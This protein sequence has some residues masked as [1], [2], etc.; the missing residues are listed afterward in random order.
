LGQNFGVGP[1][2]AQSIYV[3]INVASN[4]T[5]VATTTVTA[6]VTTPAT[7]A[8]VTPTQGNQ[9]PTVTPTNSPPGSY[10]NSL[11]LGV[12][13][14]SFNGACPHIFTFTSKIDMNSAAAIIFVLEAGS[15][16]PGFEFN[17]PAPNTKNLK[18]GMNRLHYE[19]TLSSTVNGW[20]Q[21]HIT[22]PEDLV[23][24]KVNI[25]LTCSP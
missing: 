21:I 3:I 22:S 11:E 7:T 13:K 9:T 5:V 20:V 15:D 16:T 23:S 25:S 1:T 17:L 12:D 18:V 6:T 10:I 24:N 14:E 8:T 19:M 2:A 4:G